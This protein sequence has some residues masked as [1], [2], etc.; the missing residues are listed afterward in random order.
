MAA[1]VMIPLTKLVRR[2]LAHR[3]A[4]GFIL[5]NEHRSLPKFAR[6]HEHAAP[7]QSLQ[8]SLVLKWAAQ[9]GTGSRTYYAKRL[10]SVRGFAK[11]CA[12]LDPRVQI[13]DYRLF[14]AWY[15]RKTPHLY[16]PE[17]I[18]HLMRRA[19]DLPTFRSPLRPVTYETFVGLIACT[20]LRVREAMRLRL[21]D[22]DLDAGTLRVARCK[23]SPERVLPIH[24]S[25]VSALRRYRA[26]RC[27]LHPF[28]EMFFVGRS[29]RPL[30]TTRVHYDFRELRRGIVANGARP[31]PRIHDLRHTFATRHITA[32][33]RAA[34]PVSHRLL[35]LSRYLGHRD[36]G[37]TW[38]Y[39]S[40]DPTML[41]TAS[42]R[43]QRFKNQR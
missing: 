31:A 12:A 20:G 27:R 4:L 8:T 29:G 7:G 18:R 23:F 28:G 40:A 41:R 43:F 42:V 6:F 32:W 5:E 35:L 37:D 14:G 17:E 15:V 33:S 1:F 22:V 13:P 38:W 39:I 25:T 36:F 10:M 11:Y 26:A 19:R 24:P 2:Y 9:P 34:A 16:S 21:D 30:R 3:R